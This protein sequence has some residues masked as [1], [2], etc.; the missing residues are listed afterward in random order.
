VDGG[1]GGGAGGGDTCSCQ[2]GTI[3]DRAV[4]SSL[5]LALQF[6]P[7]PCPLHRLPSCTVA[8]VLSNSRVSKRKNRS[9]F[10]MNLLERPLLKDLYGLCCPPRPLWYSRSTASDCV[11]AR[12][13]CGCL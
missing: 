4:C 1:G 2:V 6:S 10:G 12:G 13:S 9:I 7:S 8:M 11:E 5:E 3:G